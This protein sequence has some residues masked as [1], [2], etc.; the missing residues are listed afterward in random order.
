MKTK[1]KLSS[2]RDAFARN[3]IAWLLSALLVMAEYGNFQR[4]R[5]LDRICELLPHDV[6]V[7]YRPPRTA[8]Q[9][10]DYICARR[11]AS[12]DEGDGGPWVP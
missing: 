9:E 7:V 10:I 2:I 8:R 4:G 3:P 6:V 12:G 11:E 5:E 1:I